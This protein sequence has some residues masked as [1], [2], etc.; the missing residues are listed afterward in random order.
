MKLLKP[1]IYLITAVFLFGCNATQNQI[2]PE[3]SSNMLMDKHFYSKNV[4]IETVDEI[5]FVSAEMQHYIDNRLLLIDDPLLRARTIIADLFDRSDLNLTYDSGANLTASEAFTSG[6]ANC[7]SLTILAYS[8]AE[9][10]DLHAQ[11]REVLIDEYWTQDDEDI[12]LN[13]HVNLKISGASSDANVINFTTRSVIVDFMPV[14]GNL[15]KPSRVLPKNDLIAHF[16]NNK[17]AEALVRNDYKLS[18][19]YFRKALKLSPTNSSVYNNLALLYKRNNFFD[20]AES[21]LEYA[22]EL[23]EKNLNAQENLAYLYLVTDRKKS[24][25]EILRG[26]EQRRSS[27]P[28]YHIMLGRQNYHSG[29]YRASISHYRDALKLTDNNHEVYFGLAQSY[30]QMG[31]YER[32]EFN[33]RKAKKFIKPEDLKEK[34]Q[35]KVNALK[36]LTAAI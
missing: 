32:A 15:S 33:L 14:F 17:G 2:T 26:L 27:N 4:D 6:L 22:L 30:F 36:Y 9:G 1:V 16:Y 29:D 21:S 25:Q 19:A 7:L 13:G 11:F 3:L 28:F 34:Y 24:A 18:Y 31:D 10:A 5:F 23:N 20:K 12:F 35:N 8:L